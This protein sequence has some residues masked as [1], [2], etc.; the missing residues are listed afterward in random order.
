MKSSQPAHVSGVH[1]DGL[2]GSAYTN[3]VGNP[4]RDVRPGTIPAA[5]YRQGME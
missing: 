1:W 2:V 5:N 3:V 4:E